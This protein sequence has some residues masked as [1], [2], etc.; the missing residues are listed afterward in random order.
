[1]DQVAVDENRPGADQLG[2]EE[3]YKF[4]LDVVRS[5]GGSESINV[6]DLN[7]VSI[8]LS[9]FAG[10]GQLLTV[11]GGRTVRVTFYFFLPKEKMESLKSDP[12]LVPY[13]PYVI[14]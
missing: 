10:V 11:P 13:L 5:H 9:L 4:A 3:L 7:F 6:K 2:W 1:M 8:G 12:R 14:G